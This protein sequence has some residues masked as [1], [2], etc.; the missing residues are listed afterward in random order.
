MLEKTGNQHDEENENSRA[1]IVEQV[2]EKKGQ[3]LES[4][5]YYAIQWMKCKNDL[6]LKKPFCI[7]EM[8]VL[9]QELNHYVWE[10]Q[11]FHLLEFHENLNQTWIDMTKSLMNHVL[12]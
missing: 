10:S 6:E 8:L 11:E 9:R 2:M 3:I 4:T 7:W 12:E 5:S 1:F